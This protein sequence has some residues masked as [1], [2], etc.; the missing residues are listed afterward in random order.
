M[1]EELIKKGESS[2]TDINVL[3]VR[4]AEQRVKFETA[5]EEYKKYGRKDAI[6][7]DK[8]TLD[9][10][11]KRLHSIS[12]KIESFGP[13]NELAA[14]TFEE[15]LKEYNEY[16][17]KLAKLNDEK[18]KILSVIND[19][20]AKKLETFN[21]TLS[22]VNDIFS[23]VFNSIT[24]GTA[25]LIPDNA[26]DVFGGGL[27]ISIDLPNKKVHNIRGLSG[28]EKSIVAISLIMSISRYTDVPFYVL[29]EVD[30]ALD[31]V[32]SSKFSGLVK[33][34]SDS[35]QFIVISHNETTLLGADVIYGVT[36]GPEGVSRVVSVKMP[37][38]AI[39]GR[40]KD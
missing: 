6:P 32:N 19:I 9:Q 25:Q 37:K 22:S 8:E 11:N 15:N 7:D 33:A 27:D 1:R 40:T 34:Y 35:T 30:A 16:N 13:I 18:A 2:Q 24:G 21:K 23:K 20:E 39:K 14:A 3:K 5:E 31:S 38:D 12:L 10:L 28:G 17:E 26:D 36:M 4:E 29:D